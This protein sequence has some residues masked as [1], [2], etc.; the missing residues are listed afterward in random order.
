MEN[1]PRVAVIS[2]F[3]DKRHG[4]E[5]CVAEQVERLS[6]KYEIHLYSNQ[7]EDIDRSR[8]IWH[9][10]PPLPGPHLL[11]YCWWFLANHLVRWWDN[12]FRGLRC[13]LTYTPGINC[14]DA[15]V[16]SVHVLFAEFHRQV[17]DNLRLLRNPILSWARLIH[18]R[19]YYRLII[20]LERLIYPRKRSG[21]AA[22]S[23]RTAE[24]MTCFGRSDIPVIYYGVSTD[25]F[26]PENQKG[27]RDRS[28]R[29][30]GLPASAFCLLLIGNG[31]KNKGLETLL[32]AVGSTGVAELWLLVVGKDDPLPYRKA[33]ANMGLDRHVLF[34]PPRPDVEFYYAASDVYA[35]PSW[36]DAFGLP[37]L[38]AMACGLPV[39]VSSRAGVS[40]LITDGV[41]GIVLPDP[42]DVVSL[43][44]AIAS[45]RGNPVLRGALGENAARTARQYTWERNAA[46]MEILFQQVL[47]QRQKRNLPKAP[48]VQ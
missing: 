39:I 41:D 7:V 6:Q 42:K 11:G 5:R 35:G 9:R 28:R 16:I 3:L 21:L 22:I 32:A 20:G 14:F 12:N 8:F 43:A 45:L 17:K 36:E 2:P 13:D 23:K 40:E 29:A 10:I 19:L 37:P 15:D 1:R 25:R 38:E 4:T 27:L 18:R 30:L 48:G 31:W 44:R 33:I 46:Q 26:N 34:L 24:I 47:E